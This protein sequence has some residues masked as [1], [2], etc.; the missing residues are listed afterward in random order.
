M[1]RE[2]EKVDTCSS[3]PKKKSRKTITPIKNK[4]PPKIISNQPCLRK[5]PRSV[6]VAKRPKSPLLKKQAKKPAYVPSYTGTKQNVEIKSN[7]DSEI[8]IHRER[9][10][11]PFNTLS[12][13]T[14]LVQGSS[15]RFHYTFN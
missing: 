5:S 13:V 7:V 12:Y 15:S 4:T 11:G 9:S 6:N 8:S 3:P 1:T 10:P 14:Y 2:K